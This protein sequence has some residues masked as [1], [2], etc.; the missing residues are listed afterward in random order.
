MK[1]PLRVLAI[2]DDD[3]DVLEISYALKQGMYD[4][5]IQRVDTPAAF[6][7][8]LEFRRWDVVLSAY[9]LRNTNVMQAVEI[10]RRRGPDIPFIVVSDKRGE[11]ST[12]RSIR[13]GAHDF[14]PKDEIPRLIPSLRRELAEAEK[15]R[16]LSRGGEGGTKHMFTMLKAAG[17]TEPMTTGCESCRRNLYHRAAPDET[18]RDRTSELADANR[19]LRAEIMRR[20]RME[21]D[22]IESQRIVNRIADTTPDLIYL[23][24]IVER[25]AVYVNQRIRDILGYTPENVRKMGADLI[26]SLLHPDDAVMVDDLMHRHLRAGDDETAEARY[27][28][29][30]SRGEWR[31]LFSR[32]VVFKRGADGLPRLILGIAQDVTEQKKA[33]EAV[34]VSHELLRKLHAHQQSFREEERKRIAREIHDELGQML[35]ALKLDMYWLYKRLEK[36]QPLL[37]KAATM[38]ELVDSCIK[39]VKR[40]ASEL[41]PGVLDDLGLTAALE[42]QTAEFQK[43]TGVDCDLSFVP[44]DISPSKAAA[45]ALFRIFQETLTNIARHASAR[46]VR[47]RLS[48]NR[49]EVVLRVSDDGKGISQKEI[50]SPKSIGLIGMRERA[51]FLGGAVTIKG[52]KNRGTT[53]T[54]RIPAAEGPDDRED[55]ARQP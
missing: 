54:V 4:P 47:I 1:T 33:E 13:A 26:S 31:W 21:K 25:R 37:E 35:T 12:V 32:N 30:N 23:F 43:R 49:R 48:Q 3:E 53:V 41:R 52:G 42:W 11:E 28:I 6:E 24:D 10:L 19:E 2:A 45:T 40:I 36:K 7:R 38:H 16:D 8:A 5:F 44:D 50:S 14:I 39:T 15:R 51:Q 29:R 27:R 46:K 9:E 17:R 55:K 22:L 18:S 20:I 34:M